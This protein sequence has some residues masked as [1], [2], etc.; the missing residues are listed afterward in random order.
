MLPAASVTVTSKVVVPSAVGAPSTSPEGRSVRPAGSVPDQ[1]YGGVPPLARKVVVKKFATKTL[2]PAPMS[3]TA[4][5]QVMNWVSIATAGG[6]V[7]AGVVPIPVSGALCGLAGALSVIVS[8]AERV[9][10]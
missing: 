9:P 1:L 6:V 2:L 5:L 10:A 8:C 4:P 7:P 3:Q